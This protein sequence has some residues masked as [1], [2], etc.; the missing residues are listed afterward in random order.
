MT[1]QQIGRTASEQL[2]K[3]KCLPILVLLRHGTLG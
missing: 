1:I 2:L 3:T